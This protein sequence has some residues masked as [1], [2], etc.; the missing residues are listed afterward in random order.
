MRDMTAK[1]SVEAVADAAAIRAKRVTD[2]VCV[3]Y[4]VSYSVSSVAIA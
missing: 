1:Q 3:S 2:G 4:A